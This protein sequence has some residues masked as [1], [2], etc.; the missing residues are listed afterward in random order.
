MPADSPTID[1]AHIETLILRKTLFSKEKQTNFKRLLQSCD[2]A[3]IKINARQ[4]ISSSSPTGRGRLTKN[5]NTLEPESSLQVLNPKSP[6][7][8]SNGFHQMQLRQCNNYI[9][10]KLK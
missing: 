4:N 6:V 2:K 9:V 1:N 7:F 8:L 3:P 5:E 10:V